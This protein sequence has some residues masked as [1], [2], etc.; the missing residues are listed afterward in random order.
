MAFDS[1]PSRVSSCCEEIGSMTLPER[2]AG[3]SLYRLG[4]A[5]AAL[6]SELKVVMAAMMENDHH[7]ADN[8]SIYV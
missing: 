2:N 1:F 8:T 5:W 7:N 4:L 6:N 3:V